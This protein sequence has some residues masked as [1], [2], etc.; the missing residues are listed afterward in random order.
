MQKNGKSQRKMHH[1]NTGIEVLFLD[2]SSNVGDVSEKF[3]ATLK[4][5]ESLSLI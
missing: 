1:L 5:I 2:S 4:K 3:A